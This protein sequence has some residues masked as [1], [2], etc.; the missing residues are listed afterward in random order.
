MI[1][2]RD[3][4]ANLSWTLSQTL[5]LTFPM[6]CNWLNSARATQTGLSQTCHRLCRKHLDGSRWFV[7]MTFMICVHDFPHGEVSVKV[8]VMEFGLK[9]ICPMSMDGGE[10]NYSYIIVAAVVIY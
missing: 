10:S 3:F 2:V 8:G 4:V 6:H 9:V 5:S 1:C 7:S